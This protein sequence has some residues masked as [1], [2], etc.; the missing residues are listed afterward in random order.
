MH[1]SSSFFGLALLLMTVRLQAVATWH[2]VATGHMC[3]Q[4]PILVLI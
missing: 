1:E 3:E 4:L 2:V